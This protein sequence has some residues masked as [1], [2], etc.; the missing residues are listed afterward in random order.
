MRDYPVRPIENIFV[1]TGDISGRGR[2]QERVGVGERPQVPEEGGERGRR[3]GRK[4]GME[5]GE[6]GEQCN[7]G[8]GDVGGGGVPRPAD[9]VA[10]GHARK[11]G[12]RDTGGCKGR[13][14]RW[15]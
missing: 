4:Q 12:E 2:G 10:I 1:P 11:R 5:R 3:G 15:R 6:R 13:R 8:R 14:E 7:I 9:G